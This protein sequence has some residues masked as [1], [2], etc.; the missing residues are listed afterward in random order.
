MRKIVCIALFSL[1]LA[2]CFPEDLHY[3]IAIGN[4]QQA[5]T[6][7]EQGQNINA[8]N[9]D[10]SPLG[11][12]ALH[13]NLEMAKYLLDQGADVNHG[14]SEGYFSRTPLHSTAGSGSVE[15]A[16]LLLANGADTSIRNRENLTPLQ[17]AQAEGKDEIVQLLNEFSLVENSWI[18]TQ[19]TNTAEA[20]K[21]F[22]SAYPNSVFAE[23]AAQRMHER[24][25]VETVQQQQQQKLEALEASLPAEVRRDKYMVQLSS[26]LKAKRY[27]EA[28]AIFPKLE[29]LPIAT[30]P[31]L[32]F[33]YGEAFLQTGQASKALEK[34]YQYIN[35]QGSGATHYA[36]AL[37]LINQAE[38][39]L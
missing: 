39:Q 36:R 25:Q 16:K 37:E 19:E 18:T 30:D 7:L 6:L 14:N 29:A 32:K 26:A 12:A 1:F 2:G 22:L 20:Y 3:Q 27:E 28:L 9:Y 23:Q 10:G 17:T 15:I 24:Q 5:K 4:N 11:N 38:T 21:A 34:L 31:S 8:L 33:F 13:N 35:E